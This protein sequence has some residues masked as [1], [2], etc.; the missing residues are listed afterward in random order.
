MARFYMGR[1]PDFNLSL[2]L[3]YNIS[4]YNALIHVLTDAIDRLGIVLY[5]Y[6]FFSNC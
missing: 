3:K 2:I 6:M 4:I 5:P 1:A